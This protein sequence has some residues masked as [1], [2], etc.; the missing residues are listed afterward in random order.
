MFILADTENNAVEN[1][2]KELI[3]MTASHLNSI[4]MKAKKIWANLS[5]KDLNRTREFYSNLGFEINGPNDSQELV[6]FLFGDDS[7]FLHFFWEEKFKSVL[8][9]LVPDPKQSNEVVFS[10]SA[11][12]RDG[13]DDWAKKVVESGGIIFSEAAEIGK[14]Y[15]FGFSDPDGHKFNFLYWP[16]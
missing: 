1:N 12:S 8:N 11:Q 3:V 4:I 13:V 10:L 15:T 9:G 7:F 14:G 5:V 6:S 16:V 2:K